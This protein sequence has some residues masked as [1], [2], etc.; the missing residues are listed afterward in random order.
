MGS[1]IRI[2]PAD[3]IGVLSRSVEAGDRLVLEGLEFRA[4]VPMELGHKFAL[5]A[6]LKGE[7]ILKYGVPIG[8]ATGD[9]SAGAHVHLHNMK[10]D[11]IDTYTHKEGERFT[12]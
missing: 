4:D 10:S 5:E 8:S 9:I 12:Q 6:I 1:L 2:H 3:N 11:Y 7:K